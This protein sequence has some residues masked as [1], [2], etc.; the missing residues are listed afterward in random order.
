MI[1]AILGLFRP[2]VKITALQH[3]QL[4]HWQGLP[5]PSLGAP[6]AQTRMVVLDLESTGLDVTRDRPLSIGAVAVHGDRLRLDDVFTR[7]LR[8]ECAV[9]RDNVV[10]HGISPTVKEE[11]DD[12]T[13]AL[14]DFLLYAAKGPIVGYHAPFD[15]EL[16][17]REARRR[18][19]MRLGGE[20]LDLA[21]LL[22]ALFPQAGLVRQPL[23]AWIAWFG[24]EVPDRHRADVDAY[25]T[26]EL[27]LIALKQAKARGIPHF[28]A[29]ADL[30][31]TEEMNR[32]SSLGGF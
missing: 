27:L 13:D 31:R 22:P 11:G 19:G 21:W 26:A 2:A 16:L 12:P 7:V 29:L 14:L 18:L 15:R 1:D 6:L 20:W 23:D 30:A 9:Q 32:A 4:I 24:L 17:T 25:M 8:Q 10:I 28:R 5:T 3:Q